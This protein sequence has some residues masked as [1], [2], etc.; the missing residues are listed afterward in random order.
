MNGLLGPVCLVGTLLT[1]TGCG[2]PPERRSPSCKALLIGAERTQTQLLARGVRTVSRIRLERLD[3]SFAETAGRCQATRHAGTARLARAQLRDAI[4]RAS[5]APEDVRAA[6]LA[7]ADLSR[8]HGRSPAAAQA[9]WRRATLSLEFDR[10][11]A[12]FALLEQLV[13]R[14]PKA[15]EAHRAQLAL[16]SLSHLR[17]TEPTPGPQPAPDTT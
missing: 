5:R 3:R 9:L 16:E 17:P 15:P 14:H 6:L 11:R 4:A 2:D 12:A 1:A 8:L 7:Y 13:R 10:R